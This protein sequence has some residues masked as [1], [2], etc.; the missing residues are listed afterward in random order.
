MMKLLGADST[1]SELKA[2]PRTTDAILQDAVEIA[3][4]KLLVEMRNRVPVRTGALRRSLQAKRHPNPKRIAAIV[5]TD[6]EYAAPVE[7]TYKRGFM[8]ISTRAK[9]T[10]LKTTVSSHVGRQIQIR[11]KRVRKR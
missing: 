8:R 3:A 11:K 9:R 7:Y 10:E 1:L 4:D 6:A 2:L 5:Y